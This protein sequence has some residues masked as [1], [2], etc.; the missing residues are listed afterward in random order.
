MRR[1]ANILTG[2]TIAWE[3]GRMEG[4]DG[5]TEGRDKV[6]GG[7]GVWGIGVQ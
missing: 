5:E 1:G 7:S 4:N 3:K 2:V 6:K